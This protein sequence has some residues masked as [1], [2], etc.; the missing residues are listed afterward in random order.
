MLLRFITVILFPVLF[1]FAVE[2]G[3]TRDRKTQVNTE[4]VRPAYGELQKK[5]FDVLPYY[6]IK[7][8]K[9]GL[10]LSGGG[11]R[12]VA[13]LGVLEVF[14]ENDIPIDFIAGASM[15]S[16]IGGLYAIGYS[17][18][19]LHA[20]VDTTDWQ[21]I[22][23]LTDLTDRRDMFIE[24]KLSPRR[25]LFTLRFDGIVPVLPA[26]V[27]PAQRLSSFINQL[28]LQGV[29]HA[30]A[31]FDNLR[32]P[33]RSVASDIVSGDRI[34]FDSGDLVQALRASISIPLIFAP[35]KLDNMLLV[36]GGLV[37]N[38][39][40]DIA[41]IQECD[42]VIAVNTTS[43]MRTENQLGAPWEYADQIITIMQQRWN[44]DQLRLADVVITPPIEEYP[45]SD[46]ERMSLFIEEGRR[47]AQN[48]V[49]EIRRKI[50]THYSSMTE[51]DTVVY[52]NPLVYFS[53]GSAH[54]EFLHGITSDNNLTHSNLVRI[55]NT[56]YMSGWYRD[57][58][59]TVS[60][61]EDNTH[62][63][64]HTEINPVLR[65]VRFIG[66]QHIDTDTLS[67]IVSELIDLPLNHNKMRS[68][69][70]H[71]LLKYRSEGYSLA[72]IEGTEFDGST[73]VLLLAINE[74]TL[75]GMLIQGNRYTRGYVIRREFPLRPGDVFK[76][77]NAM[78]GIRNINGTG[79]FNQVFIS[80]RQTDSDPELIVNVDERYPD[81]LRLSMRI[82]E[83]N[84]FQPMIE[85]R[86]ENLFGHGIQTGLSVGGGLQNRVYQIDYIVHRLFNTYITSGI[87]G[88]YRFD[89]IPVYRNDTESSPKSWRRIKD[90][91][92]RQRKWGANISVGTQFERVGNIS[93]KLRFENHKIDELEPGIFKPDNYTL[94]AQRITAMFDTFEKYPYPSEGVGFE[95]YYE[96]ALSLFGS[97][98]SYT[99]FLLNYESYNTY[100]KR[101]TLRPRILFGFGDDTVPLSEQFVF[102]GKDS[103]LGL[104]EYDNRGRQIFILSLEYRYMLPFKIFTDAYLSARYDVGSIW[105]NPEDIRLKDFVHGVGISLGFDSGL[106]GP[107]EIA[108]GRAYQSRGDIIGQTVP[109][110]PIQTY[111]SI[112]YPLP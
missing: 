41:R 13:H 63:T 52:K 112:G 72:R 98:V 49:A 93:F 89:D 69:L 108:I 15:G 66:N 83:M 97:E 99:K 60:R 103:F 76:V 102:G 29:Y 37:S 84:H 88:F 62:I 31:S 86:N 82:D 54:G 61:D 42:I 75:G 16:L 5:T 94:V 73:G 36:D 26:S 19:A 92:Y 58:F 38:I 1:L 18:E 110:G 100:F 46:F 34:I 105:T 35:V 25:G 20:I 107:I 80:F 104:R 9:I 111:F 59:V 77:E 32:V 74:G 39:P 47:S 45:G 81:L 43:G 2:N 33:F 91:E 51:T 67:E 24:Q 68:A 101:H 12:G 95:A 106:I 85:L 70:E 50:D 109:S 23:S 56:I 53:G 14:E 8:P 30:D 44:R 17:T 96:S 87:T 27:T 11:A 79:L 90:G 78:R 57:V 6:D 40:V 4:I 64:L 55:L 10:V 21:Y 48:A 71:V 22:L 28:V 7:R 3:E 65:Q